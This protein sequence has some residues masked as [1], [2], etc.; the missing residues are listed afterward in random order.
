[1][2]RK[3]RTAQ[4][5]VPCNKRGF[6]ATMAGGDRAQIVSQKDIPPDEDFGRHSVRVKTCGKSTRNRLSNRRLG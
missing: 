1:M 2:G 4:R 3:V 5:V 6:E